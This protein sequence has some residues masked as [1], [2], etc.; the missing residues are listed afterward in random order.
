MQSAGQDLLRFA[1]NRRFSTILADPP[2]QF[3]N[4]TGKVA[5]EHKRLADTGDL[6]SDVTSVFVVPKCDAAGW[7]RGHEGVGLHLQIQYRLA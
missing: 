7:H 1:G 2:W 5:P 4:K 6:R 3:T